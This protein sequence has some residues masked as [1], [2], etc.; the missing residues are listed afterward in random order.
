MNQVS[1]LRQLKKVFAD[2]RDHLYAWEFR[3]FPDRV[4]VAVDLDENGTYETVEHFAANIPW[5]TV[6]VHLLGVSYHAQAHPQGRATRARTASS[7]GGRS[8]PG[9]WPPAARPPSPGPRAPTTR[10]AAPAGC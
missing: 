4:E 8:R 10:R 2:E 9:R 3:F 5:S 6:Y 1:S 7:P